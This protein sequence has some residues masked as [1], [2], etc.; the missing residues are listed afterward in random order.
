VAHNLAVNE[1]KRAG[2]GDEEPTEA[3]V[4]PGYDPEQTFLRKERMHRLR[5]A[6]RSLPRRQ[7]EC[8]HLRAEGLRYREI[9][10]VLRIGVSSVAES[11]Q[12][13]ME[14]LAKVCHE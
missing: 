14:T 13:A 5:G 2:A 9:A 7:Q 3:E 12:R 6:I 8:L 11:V 4:D 1:M 10:E